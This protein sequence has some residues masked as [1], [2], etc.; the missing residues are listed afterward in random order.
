MAPSHGYSQVALQHAHERESAPCCDQYSGPRLRRN[1][2]RTLLAIFYRELASPVSKIR[3][4]LCEHGVHCTNKEIQ[5]LRQRV[6]CLRR[7]CSQDGFVCLERQHIRLLDVQEHSPLHLLRSLCKRGVHTDVASVWHLKMLH[8]QEE[9]ECTQA[10]CEKGEECI[11]AS[12]GVP[13]PVRG[14]MQEHANGDGDSS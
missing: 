14:L 9:E 12:M 8:A 13:C 2:S 7:C 5:N 11:H 4:A 3:K 1:V 10:Q 6:R